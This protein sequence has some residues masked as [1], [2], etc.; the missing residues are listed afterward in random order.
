[1]LA[2]GAD[3][4]S[5]DY[6]GDTPLTAAVSAHHQNEAIIKSLVAYTVK[7]E[8][9]NIHISSEGFI[10]NKACIDESPTLTE[11]KQKCL[12]EIQEM[13]SFKIVS[14]L[15]FFEVFIQNRNINMLARYANNPNIVKC[16]NR[17][18]MYS[19]CIEKSIE[20]GKSRAK[21]LQGAAESMDEIFESNQDAFQK[22]Q[23]SW[24]HLPPEVRFM[25]LENLDNDDLTK[26]QRT[27]VAE[28]GEAGAEVEAEVKGAYAIYDGE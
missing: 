28:A 20:E 24:S 11:I 22:S 25:I 7:L 5:L 18:L 23:T 1:M 14:N 4:N 21:L 17:F 13:K 3:I 9:Y 6:F 19:S 12:Q 26:I 8:S 2:C 27:D 15:S 10:K 16:K